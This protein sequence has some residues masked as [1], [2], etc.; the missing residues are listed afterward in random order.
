M[1]QIKNARC[2]SQTP[3]VTDKGKSIPNL[4]NLRNPCSISLFL[5]AFVAS[6]LIIF[7][8]FES[9]KRSAAVPEAGYPPFSEMIWFR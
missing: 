9:T 2:S 7:F 4:R 1:T 8:E 3:R 6:W 5:R